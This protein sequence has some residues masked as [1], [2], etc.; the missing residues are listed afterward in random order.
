MLIVIIFGKLELFIN[1]LYFEI[2][3]NK[4]IRIVI[5]KRIYK[6]WVTS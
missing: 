1:D 2:F 6:S 4:F 3:I 5:I